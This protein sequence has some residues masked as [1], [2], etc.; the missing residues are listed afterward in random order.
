MDR[1]QF[2]KAAGILGIAGG[3]AGIYAWQIEPFRLEFVRQNMPIKGLP[4]GLE[5]KML[6]QISD[7]HVGHRFDYKYIIESF[8]QARAFN[9]EIVVYTGDYISY[10]NGSEIELFKDV[11]KNPVLGSKGTYAVLGNHDYG[12]AW[13]D[14]SVAKEIEG[15]LQNAGI[16]VLRN[17]ITTE[18]GLQ[19]AGLDDYWGLNFDPKKTIHK[20]D[21]DQAAILLSHNPDTV[22]L[23][24]WGDYSSWILSGHTHG[25]QVKPPFLDP[26]ILPVQNKEYDAG[27][28][29]LSGGRT[30][31]INR[32]LGHLHQI[33]FNVR[34]EITLFE[35]QKA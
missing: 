30:M 35:M 14:A 13:S 12:V 15:I 18:N 8:A 19:V 7:V 3:V 21:P 27:V 9:P 10:E 25:G 16:Q 34:P 5:G 6:M 28:F 2:L 1:R 32:A 24:I 22:D 29:N 17:E 26:P 31:Y 11:L 20:V 23:D 4:D 33:R